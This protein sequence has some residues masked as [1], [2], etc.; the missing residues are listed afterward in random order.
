MLAAGPTL[1]GFGL[2]NLSLSYLP[3]SV[4][5]LIATSELPFTAATAYFFLNE[6]LTAVQIGRNI[7]PHRGNPPT[8]PRR[9]ASRPSAWDCDTI[10]EDLAYV[11]RHIAS[12]SS[13]RRWQQ[14][15]Q[16]CS[17]KHSR[18]QSLAMLYAVWVRTSA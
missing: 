14:D 1:A 15:G 10:L 7:D 6:R 4:A 3:S 16:G 8:P 2:Y 12:A 9:P 13:T 11:S 18:I 5:N 17:R